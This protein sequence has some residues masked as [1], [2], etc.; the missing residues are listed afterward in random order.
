LSAQKGIPK[1]E[2]KNEYYMQNWNAAKNAAR[3]V[4][5]MS[6]LANAGA[7]PFLVVAFAVPPGVVVA[8]GVAVADFVPR[9]LTDFGVFVAGNKAV[10]LPL[11]TIAVAPTA[12]EIVVPETVMTPPGVN[13]CPSIVNVV[14]AFAS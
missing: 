12:R 14:P 11:M 9:A 4:T 1:Q 2:I 10:V 7:A 13:S 5:V 6:T 3:Q 8:F